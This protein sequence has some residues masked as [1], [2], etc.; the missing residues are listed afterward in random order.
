MPACIRRTNDNISRFKLRAR[1]ASTAIL[2]LRARTRSSRAATGSVRDFAQT[3]ATTRQRHAAGGRRQAAQPVPDACALLAPLQHSAVRVTL[4]PHGGWRGVFH[5][6]A[7]LGHRAGRDDW[8]YDGNAPRASTRTGVPV[9]VAHAVV[10]LGD[11]CWCERDRAGVLRPGRAHRRQHRPISS[12]SGTARPWCRA[13]LGARRGVR[14]GV[15]WWGGCGGMA[16]SPRHADAAVLGA[17]VASRR[18]AGGARQPPTSLTARSRVTTQRRPED[19]C[20]V[21][22]RRSRAEARQLALSVRRQRKSV[23]FFL[24]APSFGSRFAWHATQ[25]VA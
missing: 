8:R 25:S 20:R 23:S 24:D 22:L 19:S 12:P 13:S 11:L 17:G 16:R 5:H 6:L 14:R 4:P 9:R 21:T 10:V 18:C 1:D 3:P 15:R 2:P 7:A